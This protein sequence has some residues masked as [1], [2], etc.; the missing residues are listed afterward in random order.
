M[1]HPY[2]EIQ[3][4]A[5]LCRYRSMLE[6]D[7]R[8]AG[9]IEA[10]SAGMDVNIYFD[11][12]DRG[13]SHEEIMRFPSND[14]AHIFD[15]AEGAG[16]SLS[17]A[18]ALTRS[19]FSDLSDWRRYAQQGITCA[20]MCEVLDC[21]AEQ[22]EYADIRR[23]GVSHGEFMRAMDLGVNPENYFKAIRFGCTETEAR[24]YA[25]SDRMTILPSRAYQLSEAGCTDEEIFE[26]LNAAPDGNWA[27][28]A[29]RVMGHSHQ[30]A[31]IRAIEANARVQEFST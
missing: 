3:D 16:I 2:R 23:E 25:S 29:T 10:S 30:E 31:M 18:V 26:C 19:E 15:E 13:V 17:D 14:L 20:E 6:M 5:V 9:S 22:D 8:L 28:A 27:Y 4:V 11:L 12:V 24:A 21:D 1:G 7:R